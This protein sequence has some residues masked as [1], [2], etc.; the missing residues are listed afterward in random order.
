VS[1]LG[2]IVKLLIA[3]PGLRPI[4]IFAVLMAKNYWKT[5]KKLLAF[6]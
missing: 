2:Y 4:Y 3:I 1:P 5:A 6:N